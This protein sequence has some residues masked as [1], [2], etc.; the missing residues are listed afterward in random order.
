MK[1][2]NQSILMLKMKKLI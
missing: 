2:M 1:K